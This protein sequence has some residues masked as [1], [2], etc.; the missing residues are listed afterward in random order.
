MACMEPVELIR[1][2]A[3]LEGTAYFEFQPGPYQG[4]HWTRD[5]VFLAEEVFCYF[6]PLITRHHSEFDHYNFS[7]IPASTWKGIL[8]D[9]EE[10]A[11]SARAATCVSDLRRADV[12][13]HR[14]GLDSEF[15]GNFRS[16]SDALSK[17]AH[18]LAVWV[19]DQL[20]DHECVS[21]LGM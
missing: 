15:E 16:N 1:D 12:G 3:L 14:A 5:S 7:A 6:E 20:R 10:I 4:N 19:R 8:S 9:L 13:F 17:L 18:E 2:T 11:A 21:V